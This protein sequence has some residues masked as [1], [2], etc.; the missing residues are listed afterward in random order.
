MPWGLDQ[1]E[2]QSGRTVLITGGNSGIGFAAAKALAER[3]ARVLL[4][5]RDGDKAQAACEAIVEGAGGSSVEAVSLDLASLESVAACA[6]AVR[7]RCDE[8][9]VLI[10]N[11]GVMAIPRRLTEDGF[12]MQLGTNHFGHFALTGQLFDVLKRASDP[13]V[14]TVASLAHNFGFINFANLQSALFYN[15]WAAYGQSKLANL[16]FAFELERRIEDAGLHVVSNACHPGIAA[17]NLASAGSRM[18]GIPIVEE[19]LQ[20]ATASVVQSAEQGAL[21]T[22][23][24]GFAKEA[25]GGEYFGPSGLGETRGAPARAQV[26]MLVNN[27]QVAAELWRVSEEATG[28]VFEF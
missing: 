1:L 3:G 25:S 18:A 28:V 7:E 20:A 14:V 11:A 24:A 13:R 27:R 9:D 16:L 17:T 6:D 4:A 26:S 15:P 8:L 19:M 22:L 21:P 10:N 23:Y 2:D 5:C 12:E